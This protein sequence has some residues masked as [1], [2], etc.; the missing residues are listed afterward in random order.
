[1]YKMY[2]VCVNDETHYFHSMKAALEFIETFY[3]KATYTLKEIV[4]DLY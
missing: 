4:E 3:T 1:M 2:E